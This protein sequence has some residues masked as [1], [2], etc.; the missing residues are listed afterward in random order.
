[1][2]AAVATDRLM[3]PAP[4]ATTVDAS[5]E[6]A[7][8]TDARACIDHEAENA[9]MNAMTQNVM[10]KKP[11]DTSRDDLNRPARAINRRADRAA[12]QEVEGIPH[13]TSAT[14]LAID[15]KRPLSVHLPLL[16]LLMLE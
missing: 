13:L 9:S 4:A 7:S 16:S 5:S 10:R 2:F 12:V 1:M 8:W 15:V 11:R 3:T 6:L 14:D